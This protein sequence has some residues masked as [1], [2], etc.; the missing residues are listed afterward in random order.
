[1]EPLRVEHE[2]GK[3]KGSGMGLLAKMGCYVLQL[4][5]VRCFCHGR[6]MKG[7]GQGRIDRTHYGLP[8]GGVVQDH[9]EVAPYPSWLNG[10]GL[11]ASP[12]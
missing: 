2:Q 8:A 12:S 5:D 4:H 1:M 3:E 7:P 6:R 11:V 10:S 9:R